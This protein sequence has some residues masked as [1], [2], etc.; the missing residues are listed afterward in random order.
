MIENKSVL[1]IIPA[2]G[3]S[4]GVP[5]KNIRDLAGKPLIAWT[6]EEAQ[7][8]IYIDRLIVSTDDEEIAEIA[9]NWGCEVP[10]LRPLE[11]AQDQTPGIDPVLHAMETL[12]EYDYTMLLQPTSP[13]RLSEDIDACLEH[14]IKQSAKACVSVTVTDKSPFWMYY[15]AESSELRPIIKTDRPVLRR[16]DAPDVYVLNGAIYVAKSDWIKQNRTY[17]NAETIGFVMPK[18]RSIDIDTMIDF[19]IVETILKET[20]FQEEK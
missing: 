3:G 2:R 5:R 16:Q 9:R 19:T 18:E 20:R 7:K 10:F 1:A 4:K 8:S 13:L 17:L 14:C 15:L 12:P 11:L 6:I